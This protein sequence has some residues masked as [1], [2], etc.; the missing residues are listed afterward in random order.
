[1][2]ELKKLARK[3]FPSSLLRIIEKI[4]RRSRGLLW[5]VRFGFP[6][7]GMR[8][9]AVTGTNGKSTTC[10]YINEVLKAADYT[11]AMMTTPMMEIAGKQL[12]RTTTRTLEK[13]SEAQ[14][15]FAKAKQAGVD[16]AVL[17]VPSHALDQDRITG[18]KIKI[19]VVTNLTPEHLDYHNT[20]E[21]YARAKSLLTSRYGASSVILNRDDEWFDYFLS[22]AIGEVVSVGKN[23]AGDITISGVRLS[24]HGSAAALNT[25]DLMLAVETSL[26]GE[27]NLYNAAQASAVGLALG[28]EPERIISGIRNLKSIPGRMEPI[29]MSQKFGVLIDYAI[30]PDAIENALKTLQHLTK[31]KV[32]IVF[33]ATGDRDK[34]K[35]PLMGEAAG[36][37]ADIIYLTDDE[38]YSEKSE[39]II[40]AV[41]K[42][43][44]KVK[45]NKKTKVIPD[46]GEAIKQALQDAG[47]NDTVYITGLGHETSRNMGGKQ[48]LW[49]DKKVAAEIIRKMS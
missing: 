1:V 29:E 17:E 27:F 28:V 24:A 49:Q 40:D 41:Y 47:A 30:T 12:P 9:V 43:I 15:F 19:A 26:I 37:H 13:Q 46:R 48:V 20:M 34:Q 36:R 38:T 16:W 22:H 8:V 35:R 42:G 33:G 2:R 21:N 7:R 45:A 10:A 31:G 3:I 25:K 23:K 5:Q 11:T 32:R 39:D 18:I 4:Y 14:S 6:A 44:K